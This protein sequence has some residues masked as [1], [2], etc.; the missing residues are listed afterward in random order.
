MLGMIYS[1]LPFM[2]L[3]IYN[4]MVKIDN[5]LVEAAYDREGRQ[6]L[7]PLE[8]AVYERKLDK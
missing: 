3:P 4:V 5:S 1:L 7:A 8:A 2:I 6:M